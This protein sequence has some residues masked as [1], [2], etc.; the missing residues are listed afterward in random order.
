MTVT[1]AGAT[2]RAPARSR[3]VP[4]LARPLTSYYL[5]L[6]S[7]M[8]L[9]ALGLVMVLSASSVRS[10]SSSGSSYAV[11]Q[12]Q[13]MWVAIGLPFMALAIVLPAR[14]LR[15][16][17]Y[18]LLLI[19]LIGLVAVFLPGLGRTRYGAT[20]WV[21]LGPI[22]AQPS[23]LAK[24][25]L[26]LWGA[27]LYARKQK[28]LG[29]WRH[30]VVPLVPV[31]LLLA[32]LIM[33]E[34]D[35]GTTMVV[36]SVTFAL[37]FVV[38][39]PLRVFG[40]LSGLGIAA[41]TAL[42]V[43]EPYRLERITGYLNPFADPLNSGYQP[44]QGLY[45]LAS[46]GWFG[47]GLGAS[48]Q[49]WSYL[50]NAHT[51]YIFAIIGE[52]LGLLGTLFVVLLFA[53]LGYAGIRVAQRTKDPFVRLASAGITAWL[54]AQA[55]LNMG[56]VTK[57][58]PVT[59]IPLPLVSFGGSSLAV[60][61]LAIGM[62]ASFARAEPAAAAALRAREAGPVRRVSRRMS[63]YYGFGPGPRRRAARRRPTRAAA[64]R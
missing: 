29:D 18:P 7:A 33:L 57:L 14:T 44:I 17:A 4:L 39:A 24:L 8:L 6:G 56:A 52:E 58:V 25:A 35:L 27:D 28:L 50:P 46:G 19:S 22:T 5:I 47:V 63:A 51:D 11:F 36:V 26:V 55:L 9:V 42:A 34:P 49:K 12:R 13:L 61:M 32:T 59:G 30:L 1:V 3:R 54:L 43:A 10:L 23:E 60:S 38:G 37:L 62:L 20:R 53:V 16:L 21:Q 15:A 48:R 45:A 41:V 64:G 2:R 40:V 31:T